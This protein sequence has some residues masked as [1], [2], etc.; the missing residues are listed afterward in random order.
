MGKFLNKHTSAA[1]DVTEA[2]KVMANFLNV[3]T[4]LRSSNIEVTQTYQQ[5]LIDLGALRIQ[6]EDN[7]SFM[8][9]SSRMPWF[10]AVFG[11][12]AVVTSLQTMAVS[13]EFGRGTSSS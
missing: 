12:D 10:V 8:D 3:A 11:R 6:V 9:A 7:E 1:T 5:A 13:Y 4:Q 2:G